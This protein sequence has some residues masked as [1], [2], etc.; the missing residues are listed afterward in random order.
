M[1]LFLCIF[2]PLNNLKNEQ[3]LSTVKVSDN[4]NSCLQVFISTQKF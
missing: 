4:E 1:K 3:L 2:Y